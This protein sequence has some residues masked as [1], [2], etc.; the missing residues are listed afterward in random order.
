LGYVALNANI[1]IGELLNR[2]KTKDV[3]LSTLNLNGEFEAAKGTV[4]IELLERPDRIYKTRFFGRAD[5]YIIPEVDFKRDF[6]N[7]AYKSEDE[8]YNWKSIKT[9]LE[10]NF[11]SKADNKV[12]LKDIDKWAQGKYKITLNT[13]DKYGEKIE[14]VKFFSLYSEK[15]TE[16]PDNEVIFIANSNPVAEPREKVMLD[17]GS[18]DKNSNLLFEIEHEGKIIQSEWL[19]A[20]KRIKKEI[21]IEEKYRGGIS[22][23]ITAVLNNRFFK[24]QGTISVPWTNKELQIEYS[25]FR[26]KLLPGQEEEWKIKISGAKK[27]KVAAEVLAGMYD[28][29]LDAFEANNWS[30]SLYSNNWARLSWASNCFSSESASRIIGSTWNESFNH[31]S[32]NYA[33]LNWFDMPFYDYGYNSLSYAKLSMAKSE[34]EMRTS[35]APVTEAVMEEPMSAYVDGAVK[36][37]VLL[38]STKTEKGP[39]TAQTFGDVKVRSNLNETVF[40]FPKLM[41]D[42]NGDVIIKFTMNEALTKWKFLWLAHTK[43]LKVGTG[44][45]EIVTQKDLMVMPNAPRFFRQNDEIYFTAKVSNMTKESMKGEAILQLFDALSMKPVDA[46]FA[47]ISATQSF[48]ALGTQ[49]A[50]LVWK[51]KIPDN[52]TNPITYKVIAKSGTFSDGEENSL[53]VLSNRMLLTETMPL[54]IRGGQTKT[55][56]F[57]RMAELSQSTTL[58][59]HKY[60]LEFTPNPAWYA[61]QALPYIM[62]YPYECSEQLFSRFYANSIASSVANSHPKIKKVFDTWQNYQPDALKSNLTKNQELKYAL[63]EETPWV[64]T[65]QNEEQQ[66]KELGV[67]F[68]LN[69]MSNEMKA[70]TQKLAD[71]QSPDGGFAWFPGGD[72]SWYITQYIVEGFGHLD[73]LGVKSIKSDYQVAEMVVEAVNYTDDRLVEHYETLLKEA[74]ISKEGEKAYLEKDNLD[75]MSIHYLYARSFYR[76]IPVRNEKTLKAINYYEAQASKYWLSKSDYMQG[77]LALALHRKGIDKTTPQNIV[78]SLKERALKSEEMGMYWKYPSGYFWYEM[79]IETHCLLI[80]VFNVVAKDAEAVDNLKTYLLKAKQTTHWKTT[81]AT[82][83]A[84]YALLSTGD[85]WLMEDQEVKISIGNQRLDQSKITKEAG[86]GYFKTSWDA[87]QIKNEMSTVK[88]ENPNKNVAWGAVYWQYFE[89]LDKVTDFK[90]TPLKITKKLFKEVRTDRGPVLQPINE[91]TKLLPGNLVKVRIELKVDRD[92]EYVHMKDMRASGFEPINVLSQYKYQGGL[93]YYESTRDAA[94]NFFFDYLSKGSYVFE[95]GL[96]VNHKG[97][98]SNG[99][100]TIQCMY[101]PEFTSHSEGVR[102]KVD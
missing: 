27:D 86:T 94:T 78:K 12:I 84:C 79:P 61:V 7:M 17:F 11:D 100:T 54:P 63:L 26:D 99:V 97:N 58:R 75:Y 95:Y 36:D 31:G 76:D 49:S 2:E 83:S 64:F 55:F 1:V 28:A 56:E 20:D 18:F 34:E 30:L 68:D 32:H 96:R 45:K 21:L 102:V 74:K 40:F 70:A 33:T 73:V 14:V 60:T 92:M 6:P 51:L 85:N 10:S 4:K 91:Q 39:K 24:K 25:T 101:A 3:E 9:V 88:V 72:D 57:K 46:D 23:H 87:S 62:E 15:E 8:Y 93:G 38:D 71:R 59:H 37:E 66:K 29:S 44:Q 52:W 98:F 16:V 50:P 90:D 53:P 19:K 5:Y 48:E 65:S 80:E 41:T 13:A 69:R 81:K 22:F 35:G 42:E 47:N 89:Q 43:D 82:A 67:L 77:M